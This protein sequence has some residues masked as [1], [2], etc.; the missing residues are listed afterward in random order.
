[1]LAILVIYVNLKASN[2]VDSY[3]IIEVILSV[4]E[5]T[6]CCSNNVA[7]RVV[8][9]VKEKSNLLSE[10]SQEDDSLLLNLAIMVKKNTVMASQAIPLLQEISDLD[11]ECGHILQGNILNMN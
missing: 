1:M 6:I 5:A 7:Q 8:A 2:S 3:T 9:P 11:K 10:D 4:S